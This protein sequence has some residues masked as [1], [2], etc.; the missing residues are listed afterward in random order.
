MPDYFASV[1]T[2]KLNNLNISVTQLNPTVPQGVFKNYK[3]L[4]ILYVKLH[5]G[6]NDIPTVIISF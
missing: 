1:F 5:G 6:P 4:N 3:F 2:N